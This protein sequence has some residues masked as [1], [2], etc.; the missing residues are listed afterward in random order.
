MA[1][2]DVTIYG[3][4]IFGLS[5][6]WSCAA[7]GAKVR[8][9]DPHGVGA[10]SSGGLVGALAPHVPERWNA[11]KAFQFD[12][13]IMAED[14]WAKV[15]A[16][17]GLSSGYGRTGRLQPIADDR[18]LALAHDRKAEAASLWQGK[19]EWDVRP[20]SDFS[21]WAPDSPTGY[22]IHD[23][24]TARM[25]PRLAAKALAG[26]VCAKG[27]EVVAEGREEGRIV[28]A[29]GWQGLLA[30]SDQLGKPVGNGVKGQ[31]ALLRHDAATLPQIFADS[32]HIIPHADGTVAVGSTSERDFDDPA[33][34]D[35]ALDDVIARARAVCPAIAEAPVIERWAGVR[36]RAKSRAPMLG[37]YPGRPDHF[38]ANGG[39]KIGFG[40]GP[41]VG[42]VMADLVLDDRDTIPE[43]FKVAAS[44]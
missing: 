29:T 4:G 2:R 40:M 17:S 14:Y 8:V 26:A 20:V 22:L 44:L 23:T 35:N 33:S 16:V 11:K 31:S 28:W 6:A 39:F 43:D 25:N 24:L 3:A 21:G 5:V 32:V 10:G 41:K 36:P 37:H 7:R 18:L 15:E 9:I 34:C 19:A 30:L 12:S 27:G 38:I 42:E 13:L 1:I